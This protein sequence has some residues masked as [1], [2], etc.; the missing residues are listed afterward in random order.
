MIHNNCECD[1]CI[2]ALLSVP[3]E[4]ISIEKFERVLKKIR[5]GGMVWYSWKLW[6]FA[7]SLNRGGVIRD[8]SGK[9]VPLIGRLVFRVGG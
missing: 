6:R 2:D 3:C 9:W 8:S 1:E 7:W 4:P 5:S